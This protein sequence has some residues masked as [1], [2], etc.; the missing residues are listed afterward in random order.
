MRLQIKNF[1]AIRAAD[2][3]FDGITVIAGE[4]DAGK[5]TVGKLLFSLFHSLYDMS[6]KIQMNRWQAVANKVV[7]DIDESMILPLP[8]MSGDLLDPARL[9]RS[10]RL[11]QQLQRAQPKTERDCL[12]FV[13]ENIKIF[14]GEQVAPSDELLEQIERDVHAIYQY[15]DA[16]IRNTILSS[17]FND[18]F[19][20][21]ANS[22]RNKE[23]AD[24][25]LTL[26]GKSIHIVLQDEACQDISG[27]T[28]ILHSA[29]Y[30]DDPFVVDHLV[31]LH[32][33]T[34]KNLMSEDL[35]EKMRLP[36]KMNLL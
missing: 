5:S 4:N 8:P 31:G 36:K 6:G 28:A 2:I 15:T 33:F 23:P 3:Q 34:W 32:L 12:I 24:L 21:Q 11:L 27:E 7:Q 30:I 35:K 25:R 18:V 22:K 20:K 14:I 9:N 29:T 19:A 16:Q 13:K 1:A 26:K 17:V 10:D